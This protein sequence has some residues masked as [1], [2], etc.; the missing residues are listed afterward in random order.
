MICQA[1]TQCMRAIVEGN[2]SDNTKIMH[3]FVA[4]AHNEA[5]K[6]IENLR[7]DPEGKN[8]LMGV[9]LYCSLIEYTGTLLT[10]SE[11]KRRTGFSS[12]FRSFLEGYVDLRNHMAVDDFYYRKEAAYHNEWIKVLAECKPDN[13]YLKGIAESGTLDE[14]TK[15]H[16]DELK[17][18]DDNGHKPISV[19]DS[20]KMADM[21]EEYHSLY[22]F[23]CA[24]AHNDFRALLKRNVKTSD[25]GKATVEVYLVPPADY[26]LTRLDTTAALLL[27]GCIR[28]HDKVGSKASEAFKGLFEELKKVRAD[29]KLETA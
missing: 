6:Q 18:L 3:T 23:E 7:F 13:P 22:R 9:S 2:M 11:H 8:Q 1:A 20:L 21:E 19:F 15:W 14:R 10:L 26:C 12:V 25:E 4:K 16:K 24:E 17:A 27:D 5:L 29:M 28:C